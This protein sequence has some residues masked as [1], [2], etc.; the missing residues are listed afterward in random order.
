MQPHHVARRIMQ[1]EID[2]IERDDRREPL[3]EIM[4]QL[5]QVAVRRDRFGHLQQQAQ[6]VALS[7]VGLAGGTRLSVAAAFQALRILPRISEFA[8]RSI[9]LYAQGQESATDIGHSAARMKYPLF[10]SE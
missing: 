2:V 5:A 6:P 10:C 8:R 4:K 3:G 9:N 1:D 7:P